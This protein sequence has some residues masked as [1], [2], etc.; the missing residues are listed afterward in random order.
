MALETAKMPSIVLAC[1]TCALSETELEVCGCGRPRLARFCA[2]R[3][4]RDGV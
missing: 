4:V 2:E 3:L 1:L